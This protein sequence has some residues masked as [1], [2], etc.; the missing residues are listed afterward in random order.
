MTTS[1]DFEITGSVVDVGKLLTQLKRSETAR[2]DTESQLKS[3]CKSVQELKDAS[4]KHASVKDKLQ[5]SFDFVILRY[6][7]D[8]LFL[9]LYQNVTT[10]C[11]WILYLKL[12]QKHQ[13]Q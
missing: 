12:L 5:V 13:I 8:T 7:I 1:F 6:E 2:S 4:E 9:Q 11:L 3:A 10:D